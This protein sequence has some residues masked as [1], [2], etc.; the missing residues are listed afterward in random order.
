[1]TIRK[2][3][4]MDFEVL[5][6]GTFEVIRNLKNEIAFTVHVPFKFMRVCARDK[7]GVVVEKSIPRNGKL[8][9][10][11]VRKNFRRYVQYNPLAL[12]FKWFKEF[13]D[14]R[15]MDATNGEYK[16]TRQECKEVATE[17]IHFKSEVG[18]GAY[19]I[20]RWIGALLDV[21]GRRSSQ[22]VNYDL[23]K[24]QGIPPIIVTISGGKLTDDSIEDLEE[25]LNGMRGA[26]NWNR[27]AILES[28]FEST[29]LDEKG[30]AKIDIKNLTQYRKEDL[31]FTTYLEKTSQTIRHR[32]RLPPLYIGSAESFTYATAKASKLAAEEQIFIPERN[33]FDEF[34]NNR[35]IRGEF[36]IYDWK[37]QS[38]GPKIVGAEELT[39]G[40]SAFADT[41]AFTINNAIEL[42]NE[43]FGM[44]MSKYDA[45]WANYPV[46]MVLELVKI[47]K[48]K[49]IDP[50]AEKL[51]PDAEA[52]GRLSL[53]QNSILKS[54][55]FS[56]EEKDLYK[57]LLMIQGVVE[58]KS[59]GLFKNLM[60]E[61]DGES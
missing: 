27:I 21:V 3:M 25:I 44:N 29:G 59:A 50:I 16:K 45:P 9:P 57:R 24:N 52:H 36:K 26:A 40:V 43:A 1:M 60:D 54:D 12:G 11:K 42:A 48:L 7:R 23:F 53:A 4:R 31:M 20:P 13:G 39:Q 35:I 5:G 34:V 33:D 17:I 58:G 47:A 55:I 56:A 22:Y 51:L 49:G 19:G 14:P 18:G 30:S 32:Y 2:L 37:Y 28:S 46:A 41:G 10:I 6:N 38:L 8:V 15:I 61:H